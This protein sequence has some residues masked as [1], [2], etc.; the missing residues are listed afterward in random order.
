LSPVDEDLLEDYLDHALMRLVGLAPYRRRAEI[1]QELREHVDSLIDDG[2]SVCEALYELGDPW[3]MGDRLVVE[4]GH[5]GY[6]SLSDEIFLVAPIVSALVLGS[7]RPANAA[8]N[9]AALCILLAGFCALCAMTTGPREDL[10]LLA[11]R[12]LVFWTLPA[13]VCAH[14]SSLFNRRQRR[15]RFW[16][17]LRMEL[18]RPSDTASQ[19]SG[20][21]RNETS[22]HA[23]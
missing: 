14:F 1:R 19:T 3:D 12:A 4:P 23:H 18:V 13:A 15:R 22:L 21:T 2:Q 7:A 6:I 10:L 16:R 20:G 9:A 17:D 11:L 5:S 8:K